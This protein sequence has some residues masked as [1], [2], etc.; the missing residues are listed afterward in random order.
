MYVGSMTSKQFW[1]HLQKPLKAFGQWK[2][3]LYDAFVPQF[4]N[5]FVVKPF[6]CL[7]THSIIAEKTA[8]SIESIGKVAK[9]YR[10]GYSVIIMPS[11]PMAR[12]HTLGMMYH[13]MKISEQIS[14][15][16]PHVVLATDEITFV[17]VKFKFINTLLQRLYRSI[18]T[19][20]QHIML[21]R[22][23][24]NS[25]FRAGIDIA[26][27]LRNQSIVVMA[28][29]GY[30]RHD[31][32]KYV[33]IPNMV[34]NFYTKLKNKNF[35]PPAANKINFVSDVVRA[36]QDVIDREDKHVYRSGK[37]SEHTIESIRQ[38]LRRNMSSGNTMEVDDLVDELSLSWGERFGALQGID[39]VLGI[40]V[41]PRHKTLVLPVVFTEYSKKR[42]H[43]DIRD[44]FLIDHVS[45]TEVKA[46]LRDMEKIQRCNIAFDI[47]A[48][49]QHLRVIWELCQFTGVIYQAQHHIFEEYHAGKFPFQEIWD[50][51]QEKAKAPHD[52][53][54]MRQ[55]ET[56]QTYLINFRLAAE[57]A[58]LDEDDRAAVKE[59]IKLNMADLEQV[60]PSIRIRQA[61]KQHELQHLP[62]E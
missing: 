25:S 46:S 6:L 53:V 11:H 26:R 21:N 50:L 57:L 58:T 41:Q 51:L 56:Y 4:V 61:W 16:H 59:A 55:I 39:P 47:L 5:R 1:Q 32:R 12:R 29:E 30:P 14:G 13:C 48:D 18:G 17:Y 7:G 45:Y 3:H 20:G 22:N 23:D 10:Q 19:L 40:T 15:H 31:S 49:E 27:L 62:V 36:I 42:L 2:E 8:H 54:E 60:I 52:P 34:E 35:L 28:G 38:L 43:I 9:K 44:F 33:D 24:P 37:L